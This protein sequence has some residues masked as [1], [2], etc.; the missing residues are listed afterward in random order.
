MNEDTCRQAAYISSVAP[1]TDIVAVNEDN[2]GS[3]KLFICCSQGRNGQIR[4][5]KSGIHIR[6]DMIS[7]SVLKK[8]DFIK[9]KR[10]KTSA[11]A[12]WSCVSDVN[13]KFLVVSFSMATAIFDASGK[14]QQ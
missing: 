11:N 8:Y 3:D 5:V 10:D 2:F 14:S 4:E 9:C 7:K 6:L 1:I 12:M 13:T